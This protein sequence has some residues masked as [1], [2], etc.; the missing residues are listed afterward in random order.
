MKLRWSSRATEDVIRIW[1]YIAFRR[2]DAARAVAQ[3]ITNA[4]RQLQR[5][6]LSGR[7]GYDTTRELPVSRTPYVLIYSVGADAVEVHRV[8][9]GAQFRSEDEL[10]PDGLPI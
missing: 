7:A 2:P 10:G 4:A 1:G 5:H 6:P 8:L 9:H 3:R